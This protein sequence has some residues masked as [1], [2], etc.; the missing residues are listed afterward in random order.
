MNI[1][2]TSRKNEG[3]Q[4]PHSCG[5]ENIYTAKVVLKG[6]SFFFSGTPNT[7]QVESWS[8]VAQTQTTTL[9]TS[10]TWTRERQANGKLP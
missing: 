5:N 7:L 3:M 4:N 9:E 8:L 1:F 10:T 6:V 2:L